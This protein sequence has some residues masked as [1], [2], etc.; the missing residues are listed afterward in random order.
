MDKQPVYYMSASVYAWVLM[1]SSS[2]SE[3]NFGLVVE[4]KILSD[5]FSSSSNASLTAYKY[6]GQL[7]RL[8]HSPES[9]L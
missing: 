1:S 9:I 4:S 7:Q 8:N 2:T 3:S 5:L 6:S